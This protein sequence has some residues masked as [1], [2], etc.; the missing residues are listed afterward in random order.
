[1]RL[2]RPLNTNHP[3]RGTALAILGVSLV[4]IFSVM[5]LSLDGGLMMAEHRHARTVADASAYAAAGLLYQNYSIGQGLDTNG[6]SK[7]IALAIAAGNGYANDGVTSTVT[8]NIP[9]LSGNF[10]G[11]SGYAEVIVSYNLPKCFSAIWGSG[12][13]TVGARSVA[14]GAIPDPNIGFL[15]LDPTMPDSLSMTG[16]AG[17]NVTNGSVI[18][19]SNNSEAVRSTGNAQ[20]IASKI[21]ITGSGYSVPSGAFQGT[22]KTGVAP[23]PDPLAHLPVPSTSGM[24]VQSTSQLTLTGGSQTIWPGVYTGGISLT[25]NG[26]I[27]MMPGIYYLN[28]GGLSAT[29]GGSISGS[30][31]MI[32]NAPSSSSDSISLTGNGNINLTP[33][34]SGIYAGI[35]IYQARTA[36]APLSLTGNGAINITGGIYAAAAAATLTGNGGTNVEGSFFIADSA[37]LTGN[38]QINVGVSGKVIGRRDMRIVE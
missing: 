5:A 18:I 20:V 12:T 8:V 13:L 3:R 2:T 17:V 24:T 9:P 31:V 30:G 11:K 33:P 14:R 1:M 23:T 16:N 19:D 4:L 21:N 25:G 7:S 10:S 29:G 35:S 27:T 32:Y 28:G 26:S 15:L 38:G 36:T 6:T 37:R 22:V 34:T